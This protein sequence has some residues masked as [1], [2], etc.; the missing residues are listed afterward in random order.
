MDH[1]DMLTPEG[2]Q[3]FRVPNSGV[4]ANHLAAMVRGGV[5]ELQQVVCVFAPGGRRSRLTFGSAANGGGAVPELSKLLDKL[6][7]CTVVCNLQGGVWAGLSPGDQ[8]VL[9]AQPRMAFGFGVMG[10]VLPNTAPTTPL[11]VPY[12]PDA[13]GRGTG[14]VPNKDGYLSVHL[15]TYVNQWGVKVSVQE[16]AHRLV[17][18]AVLGVDWHAWQG[19]G[20]ES[21]LEV[22]HMCGNAWCLYAGHLRVVPPR[23]N[24]ISLP[25]LRPYHL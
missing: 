10:R 11:C 9:A 24:K 15:G 1:W 13:I 5:S 21:R 14:F 3:A 25:H 12:H 7:A 2:L 4:Q 6:G 18:G 17:A 8:A 20:A 16:L 19:L 22:C 23:D